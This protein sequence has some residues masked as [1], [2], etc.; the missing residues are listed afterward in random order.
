MIVYKITNKINGKVYVG[1]DSSDSGR[2][3]YYHCWAYNRIDIHDYE[4]ILYRAFRKYGIENFEYE[5]LEECSD[6]QHLAIRETYW[7]NQLQSTNSQNGYNAH[8]LCDNR[9][10]MSHKSYRLKNPEGL[11][12]DVDNLSEFCKKNDLNLGRMYSLI[13]GRDGSRTHKGWM[14]VPAGQ[15]FPDLGRPSV[16]SRKGYTHNKVRKNNSRTASW[17]LVDPEGNPHTVINLKNFCLDHGLQY[18]CMLAVSYGDQQ[19][20]KGWRV[21]KNQNNIDSLSTDRSYVALSDN[22]D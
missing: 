11:V 15:E 10:N 4:K 7:I 12:F 14:C 13:S 17:F 2:R 1:K 6:L 21:H 9:P 19:H 5:I 20:H 16:H 18:R 8:C 22:Q 3:W